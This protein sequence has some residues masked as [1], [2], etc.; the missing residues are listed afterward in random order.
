MTTFKI[1][2]AAVVVIVLV[3]ALVSVGKKI[4]PKDRGDE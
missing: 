4:E 3:V 2:L 1:I